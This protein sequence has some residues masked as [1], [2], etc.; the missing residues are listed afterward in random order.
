[1]DEWRLFTPSS[2]QMEYQEAGLNTEGAI[3]ILD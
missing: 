3:L 1:M 2:A